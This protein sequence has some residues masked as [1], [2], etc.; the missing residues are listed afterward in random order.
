MAFIVIDNLYHHYYYRQWKR[1]LMQ[2]NGLNLKI[3][4]LGKSKRC[5]CHRLRKRDFLRGAVCELH[6]RP[7]GRSWHP[8]SLWPEKGV[9]THRFSEILFEWCEAVSSSRLSSYRTRYSESSCS[10]NWYHRIS[11]WFG[12]DYIQVSLDRCFL[13]DYSGDSS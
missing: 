6:K 2:W 7:L 11:F 3:T 9:P 12:T 4:F 10:D 8:G 5:S 13:R 1:F